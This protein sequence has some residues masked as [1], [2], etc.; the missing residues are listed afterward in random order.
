MQKFCL[1]L[2]VG[3]LSAYVF[4]KAQNTPCV[5]DV[6]LENIEALSN[7]EST[8]PIICQGS[9][10]YSCPLNGD[11]YGFIYIGYSLR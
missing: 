5:N 11:K 6:L 7:I 4:Q 1:L 10:E 9:G 8:L 3:F 2:L